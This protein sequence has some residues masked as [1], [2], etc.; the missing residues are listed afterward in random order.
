[1]VYI[2]AEAEYRTSDTK[3]TN[4]S[5]NEKLMNKLWY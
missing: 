3:R 4:L 2:V 5:P 1:M